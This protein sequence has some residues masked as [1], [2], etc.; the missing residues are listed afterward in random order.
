MVVTKKGEEQDR[1]QQSTLE[2]EQPEFQLQIIP[3]PRPVVAP[4]LGPTGQ[5]PHKGTVRLTYAGLLGPSGIGAV[6]Y[7]T[8]EDFELRMR[9]LSPETE[10]LTQR[11]ILLYEQDSV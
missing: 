3:P 11:W 4:N 6:A 1:K 5:V 2:L 8:V 9:P 7:L 10:T